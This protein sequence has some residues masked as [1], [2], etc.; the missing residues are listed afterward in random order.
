MEGFIL[1]EYTIIRVKE[2]IA[3]H[4]FQKSELLYR[5]FMAYKYNRH[6][7]YLKR[8]YHYITKDFSRNTV[9]NQLDIGDVD[10]INKQ[11]D[12]FEISSGKNNIALHVSKKHIRFCC[13]TMQDAETLLFIPL[14]KVYPYLFVV[15]NDYVNYGW[16]SPIL[17]KDQQKRK[18]VL[19]S[20]T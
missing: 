4:Y 1:P 9:I 2:E 19:Y 12:P 5:F 3:R 16:V 14:R 20:Y 15:C 17:D 7:R 13:D 10:H 11:G 8:Q 6:E 18:Q